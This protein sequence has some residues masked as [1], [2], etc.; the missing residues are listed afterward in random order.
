MTQAELLHRAWC[1]YGFNAQL[2][3]LIE[4]AGE[5]VQAGAKFAGFRT[6]EPDDLIEE[7]ADVEIMIDQMRLSWGPQIDKARTTKLTRLKERMKF[8][9]ELDV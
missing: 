3:M 4:E 5:L 8:T 2:L 9:E 6:L 7:I 1:E